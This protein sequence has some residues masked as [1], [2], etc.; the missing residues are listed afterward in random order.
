MLQRGLLLRAGSGER[1]PS[2]PLNLLGHDTGGPN[3]ALSAIGPPG[4]QGSKLAFHKISSLEST[5]KALTGNFKIEALRRAQLMLRSVPRRLEPLLLEVGFAFWPVVACFR[6]RQSFAVRYL[7]VSL[8][9]PGLGFCEPSRAALPPCASGNMYGRSFL[10][11]SFVGVAC[12]P[13]LVWS[14]ATMELPAAGARRS[15]AIACGARWSARSTVTRLISE[16]MRDA[17]S[18][19]A[20]VGPRAP[21]AEQLRM[22]GEGGQKP[23]ACQPEIDLG[24]SAAGPSAAR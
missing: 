17:A 19:S 16:C 24:P 21:Q 6:G 22:P 5:R 1:T 9:V 7:R 18:R 8:G 20:R 12:A 23:S 10:A 15:A 14:L 2:R 13:R 4:G 11:S 3:E